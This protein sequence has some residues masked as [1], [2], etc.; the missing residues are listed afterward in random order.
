M[1]TYDPP[2]ITDPENV[3]ALT[4]QQIYDAFQTVAQSAGDVVTAWQQAGSQWRT[5]TTGL[6]KA[7]RSAVDGQW[8]GASAQAAVSALV[9]YGKQAGELADLFDAAGQAVSSTAQAALTTKAYIPE[10][11]PVSADQTKDPSGFDR[12]TRDASKAQDDA[13]Q[14]MQQRYVLPFT[15][16][17]K[18]IPTFPAAAP[19]ANGDGTDPASTSDSDA[20]AASTKPTAW[21][22]GT[23][24]DATS[25]A[26]VT[27][28]LRD[29]PFPASVDATI[30]RFLH[31]PSSATPS[32]SDVL[33][34]QPTT[35]RP[36]RADRD[37][38]TSAPKATRPTTATPAESAPTT[39]SSVHT[40]SPGITPDGDQR[41]STAQ[42]PN[43]TPQQPNSDHQ[44]PGSDHPAAP[45]QTQ[46]QSTGTSTDAVRPGHDS[47]ANPPAGGSSPNSA[48]APNSTPAPSAPST[49]SSGPVP[50]NSTPN[51]AGPALGSAGSAG[52]IPAIPSPVPSTP[53]PVPSAPTPSTPAPSAPTPAPVTPTPAPSFAAHAPNQPAPGSSTPVPAPTVQAPAPGTSTPAPAVPKPVPSTPVPGAQAPAAQAAPARPT[54]DPLPPDVLAE[55]A[56]AAVTGAATAEVMSDPGHHHSGADHRPP[57]L[58]VRYEGDRDR[59]G[60]KVDLRHESH[61]AEMTGRDEHV[62]PT[63]GE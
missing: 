58:R 51:L 38:N 43:S 11:V 52:S 41:D 62:Q 23:D 5:S 46:T 12:Q 42:R 8:S 32:T 19:L 9:D 40:D 13:R 36:S 61:T 56:A 33:F 14:V 53:A 49:G 60:K 2:G 57:R 63:I 6:V 10:P 17:D 35:S 31:D 28:L 26:S 37:E 20:P 7:V 54:L 59:T 3:D 27:S 18:R 29:L 15:D 47:M 44:Q 25:P 30:G 24:P 1:T 50:G 21:R 48:P 39:P 22:N 16:Q 45:E 4:H 55:P 34:Q